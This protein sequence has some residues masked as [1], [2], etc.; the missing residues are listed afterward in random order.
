MGGGKCVND[1]TP[2]PGPPPA[3]EAVVPSGVG[4]ECSRHIAPWCSGSQDPE[5]AIETTTVVHPRNS[6]RLVGQHRLDRGP[7]IVGEF[8]AY[9][10]K[11]P[12]WEFES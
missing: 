2:H 11:P 12:I 8:I 5:N 9:D 7:F 4:T 1:T 10:S 3:N 6:T